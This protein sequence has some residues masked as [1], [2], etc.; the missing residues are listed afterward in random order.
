VKQRLGLWSVVLFGAALLGVV[1]GC[2]EEEKPPV[3][4]RRSPDEKPRCSGAGSA[5]GTDEESEPEVECPG[6][7]RQVFCVGEWAAVCSERA[8]LESLDNC[9]Q[10]ERVCVPHGCDADGECSGCRECRPGEVRCDAE[11]GRA[12][13]RED[14][15]GYDEAEACDSAAGLFCNPLSGECEDLCQAAEAASTYIGCEYWAVATSN[16]QLELEYQDDEG[17]CRPFAFAAVVSNPQSVTATVRVNSPGRGER[18]IA[19]AP[20]AVETIELP[21]A[22]ELRG[23][24]R[25]ENFSVQSASAAHHIES[26]VPVTV[27]QFNPLEFEATLSDGSEVFSHTNDASLL[28]PVHSLG[29]EYVVLAQPT[30]QHEYQMTIGDKETRRVSGPGFVAIIGVEDEPVAVAIT[31][32]AYTQ[33]SK[34][35]SMPAVG[36]GD[37][38]ELSLKKGEVVQLISA[39]PEDCDNDSELDDP[40]RGADIRYCRTPREYDLTGT[41]IRAQGRVS[42]IAGH[43]CVFLPYNRWACD[44][45]E[46]SLFPLE[47]WGREVLLGVSEAVACQPTVPNMARVVAASDE[48][49][50]NFNPAVHEP[51]VLNAGEYVELEFSED[52]SVSGNKAI[53]VGQFLLGQEYEGMDSAPS[54]AKGDPSMSLGI[55]I[56]QWRSDY[57]F[58]TP[59]TYTDNFANVITREGQVAQLDGRLV[60]GFSPIEGTRMQI[61]RVPVDAG[62]HRLTSTGS[63]GL[64]LYGYAPFTS[65]MLPGGLDLNKINGP[66]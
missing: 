43:D 62:Q 9:R 2:A 16:S 28:L 65:Y 48:T 20:G 54:F 18:Q 45:I 52:F 1:L 30:L 59:A 8:K 21:C 6:G 60:R 27:Y 32:S 29:S 66:Q 42:V 57:V 5:V 50:I 41:R 13:C 56:E 11:G 51:V 44:H 53:M 12:F 3:P 35:G 15:S 19:V 37:V 36:P 34:D 38:L 47:A 4:T 25:V 14:G 7:E 10:D 40:V 17:I 23:Q 24:V 55:P 61:A 64:V 46:E 58:L 63:V 49:R 33:P 22:L 31:S 26:D 39:T